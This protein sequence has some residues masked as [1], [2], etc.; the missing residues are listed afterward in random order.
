MIQFLPFA[1]ALSA[2][3]VAKLV[4]SQVGLDQIWEETIS[5]VI[6]AAVGGG[7]SKVIE[8][9]GQWITKGY[10]RKTFARLVKTDA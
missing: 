10:I 1:A 9:I 6:V 8:P 2:K 3:A 7:V 5:D 4:I